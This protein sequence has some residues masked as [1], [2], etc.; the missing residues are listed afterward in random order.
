[1][2]RGG[3]EPAI[4]LR[5][6]CH[7]TQRAGTLTMN[8]QINNPLYFLG[9]A[10]HNVLNRAHDHPFSSRHTGGANFGFCDGH[11]VFLSASMDL[12]AYQELGSRNN[13]GVSN[14]EQ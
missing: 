10:N 12:L 9:A 7:A 3:G 2:R 4:Q 11:V 14:L 6:M 13:G 1:M 5:W 8:T